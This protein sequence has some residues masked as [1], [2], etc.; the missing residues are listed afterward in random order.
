MDLGEAFY[1][2][3]KYLNSP[4]VHI[5]ECINEVVGNFTSGLER[6]TLKP[7]L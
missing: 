4:I 5:H 1:K 3:I 2:S 7:N 6:L